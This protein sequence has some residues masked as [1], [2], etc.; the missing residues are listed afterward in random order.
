MAAVICER[1][2]EPPATR[3]ATARPRGGTVRC[4]VD[5][6]LPCNVTC[7]LC[8]RLAGQTPAGAELIRAI[9]EELLVRA[10][11]LDGDRIVLGIFGGEPLLRIDLVTALARETRRAAGGNG[12]CCDALLSTNGTLLDKDAARALAASGVSAVQITLAG[13]ARL[14]DRSRR[15]AT[16]GP[17]FHRIVGNLLRARERLRVVIR[18]EDAGLRPDDADELLD[19]LE[20]AGLFD[21]PGSVLLHLR[22]PATYEQQL[23]ALSRLLSADPPAGSVAQASARKAAFVSAHDHRWSTSTP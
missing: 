19:S 21:P 6:A 11:C 9:Q 4:M 15:L 2:P 17:T 8:P 7:R 23:R 5:L 10:R 14:H 22:K 20:R 13:P 1:E 18:V 16:G 3:H 12:M